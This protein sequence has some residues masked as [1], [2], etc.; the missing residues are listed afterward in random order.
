MKADDVKSY[1]GSTERMI[2]VRIGEHITDSKY[3]KYRKS[4]ELSSHI[5]K[6][7][8]EGK[9]YDISWK[10]LDKV[11]KLRNGRDTCNVCLQEKYRIMFA[12]PSTALNKKSEFLG[13]CRHVNKFLLSNVKSENH[14]DIMKHTILSQKQPIVSLSQA[15]L[16]QHMNMSPRVRVEQLNLPS[17]YNSSTDTSV[18]SRT[19]QS[20]SQNRTENPP[21]QT[22]G[23]TRRV[24]NPNSKYVGN[25]WTK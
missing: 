24:R 11:S 13:K 20:S 19:R 12:D 2:K 14:I 15:N 4:T 18:E 5:W 16:P 6:L 9:Q 17:D 25:M 21:C 8:D 1:R 3:E 10:I 23:R 7:K 22:S